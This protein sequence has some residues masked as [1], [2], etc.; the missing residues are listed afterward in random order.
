MTAPTV[1]V[2]DWGRLQDGR[3]IERRGTRAGWREAAYLPCPA[4]RIG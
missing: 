4:W 3:V 2:G 1:I